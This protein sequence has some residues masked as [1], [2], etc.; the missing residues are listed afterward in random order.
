MRHVLFLIFDSA[1]Y[2]AWQAAHTPN[3][4]QLGPVERRWSYSSWTFP[5]HQVFLMGL[6][7]HLNERRVYASTV[8][9]REFEGWNKR[10]GIKQADFRAFIPHFSLPEFLK[11]Q[12][13]RTEA[14]VSMPVL[15]PATNLNR[16]FDKYEL[17]PTPHEGANLFRTLTFPT[18]APGFFFINLGET[19]YPYHVPGAPELPVLHGLHGVLK[20]LGPDPAVAVA[21]EWLAPE[22]FKALRE[23]QI[24]ALENLDRLLPTLLNRVPV[25]ETT[26]I[27]TA[28]HGE[29]FGEDGFFGHG[30]V[31][32]EKVFEVP[33]VEAYL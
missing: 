14:Y 8:Y 13:Y 23:R 2:D 33:Y 31:F 26:V 25:G 1:R 4:D 11:Q 6:M 28:D 3:L 15:N 19:H 24:Q 7:P 21:Q 27:I 30:P 9:R 16:A 20:R 18:E 32:H 17:L 10:L 29:L 5:A 12:G 22:E